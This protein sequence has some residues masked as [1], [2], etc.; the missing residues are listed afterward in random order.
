MV[1]DIKVVWELC[2]IPGNE[3]ENNT[4]QRLRHMTWQ[5]ATFLKRFDENMTA[6]QAVQVMD[7][8]PFSCCHA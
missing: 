7:N 1:I 5:D 3:N 8:C 4:E 6:V 2:A